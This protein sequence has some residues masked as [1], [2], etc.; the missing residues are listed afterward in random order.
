MP[1]FNF[2]VITPTYNRAAFLETQLRHLAAE[3]QGLR[4]R[5]LH[6]I[7]DDGSDPTQDYDSIIRRYRG[8]D[9]YKIDYQRLNR[10]HGRDEFWRVCNHLFAKAR[11]VQFEFAVMTADDLE[12]CRD[13]L[14]RIRTNFK[15][16]IRQDAHCA[17][18]NIFSRWPA[19]WDIRYEDGAFI[20]T[21]RFFEAFQ[22]QVQPIPKRRW[23]GDRSQKYLS[24]GVHQQITNRLKKSR[25]N[26]APATGI[27][28]VRT[29]ECE[30]AL[31]PEGRFP[32]RAKRQALPKVDLYIDD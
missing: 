10:N 18:M 16:L 32:G 2:V 30:S 12:L 23:E 15:F 20:A 3:A 27:S 7:V 17:C 14:K 4:E 22:W 31:Y 26:I 28:Y 25:F 13:F 8:L 24:T 6:I 19:N 5:V 1:R 11:S 29:R 21:R 9:F